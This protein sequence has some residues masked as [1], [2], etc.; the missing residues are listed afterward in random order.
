VTQESPPHSPA[1][2]GAQ[3][4]E[5]EIHPPVRRRWATLALLCMA[6]FLLI[7]DVTVINVALPT[8]GD[9]LAPDCRPTDLGGDRV[10]PV[11]RQSAAARR[12]RR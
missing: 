11:L 4:H 8:V 7:V 6:Q 12:P 3:H 9:E 5:H 10:H 2:T 1:H